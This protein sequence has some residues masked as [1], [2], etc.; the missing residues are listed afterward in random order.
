VNSENALPA[1][2]RDSDSGPNHPN[3]A[4]STAT[5]S[6]GLIFAVPIEG[7]PLLR[8]LAERQTTHGAKLAFDRGRLDGVPVAVVGSGMGARA[9]ADATHALIDGHS[10]RFVVSFGFCGG[11]SPRLKRGDLVFANELVNSSGQTRKLDLRMADDPD[12]GV[13]VGR[14][15]SHDHILSNAVEKQQAGAAFAAIAVDMETYAVAD[16]CHERRQ[17]FMSVRIVSDTST[18]DLPREILSI[19]GPTGAVRFGGLVGALWNR[20]SSIG[21][22]WKLKDRSDALAARLAG[23]LRGVV[24]QLHAAT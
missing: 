10:P 3:A 4:E 11:L 16:V 18:E 14:L 12:A 23:V 5:C 22:L 21:D 2:Q 7:K 17:R 9:A 20:P 15:L 24:T 6:V 19:V 1:T 8:M 13:H